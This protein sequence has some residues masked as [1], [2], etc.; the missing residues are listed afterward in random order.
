[1]T[2]VHLPVLPVQV[3]ELLAPEPGQTFVDATLGGGGHACLIAEKLGTTG[4]LIALDR[5]PVALERARTRLQQVTDTSRL[6]LVHSNFDRLR[7]VLDE[8]KIDRV[9]GV[10][11]DLGFSSDQIESADRGLSFQREGPLDMR[12]DPTDEQ[13]A[14]DIIASWSE[15]D[16]ADLFFYLGEER[17]SRRIARRIV[18]VRG[19][20]PITTTLQLADLVRS[21]L[22]RS[23]TG[24]DP[25]TRVFQALR[26]G[27][28]DELGALKR[29]VEVLPKCVKPGGRVAIISFH[30]LEDRIVKWAFR[31][32]ATWEILTKKPVEANEAEEAA[33][34]RSRSAKLRVA[35]LV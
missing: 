7:Q 20:T 33:N 26:I 11:A 9:D 28:N 13:T 17:Q 5:D 30:S 19:E 22:P 21:C 24:L 29:L 15:S 12:L 16:L 10:L 34:P 27:V 2:T 32:S 8:L 3:L 25:A 35:T 31:E 18:A 1:M 14:G 6:T 23:K 4:H